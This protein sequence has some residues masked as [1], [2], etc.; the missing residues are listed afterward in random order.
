MAL[1]KAQ[2]ENWRVTMTAALS[3]GVKIPRIFDPFMPEPKIA[4]KDVARASANQVR[5]AIKN[6]DKR[7]RPKRKAS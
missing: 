5:S 2:R 1:V 7:V 4:A 3:R 6:W